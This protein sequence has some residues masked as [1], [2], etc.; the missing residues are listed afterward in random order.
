M[1]RKFIKELEKWEGKSVQ[2]PMLVIGARQVGKT[3]II[4]YFCENKYKD[5]VYINL[6]EHRDL[7]SV[8]EDD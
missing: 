8:F 2:E 1:Y 4:K 5:Y 7:I 3:W 6:E